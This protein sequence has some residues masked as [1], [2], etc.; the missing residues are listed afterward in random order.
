MALRVK[1]VTLE[2]LTDLP[3]SALRRAL[4]WNQHLALDGM[5][6][7]QAQADSIKPVGKRARR[8]R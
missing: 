8:R 7:R 4:W 6:V 3:V 5:H 2:V 1:V